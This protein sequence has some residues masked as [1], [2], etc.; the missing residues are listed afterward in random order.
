[1][2][3]QYIW[4]EVAEDRP[5]DPVSIGGREIEELRYADDTVLLSTSMEG[6]NSMVQKD[7]DVSEKY[8]LLIN[9]KKTQ[10]MHIDRAVNSENI[11]LNGE[12][13]KVVNEFDY[14]GVRIANNCNDSKE[15]KRRLAIAGNA[16]TRMKPLWKAAS[17]KL[18]LH[19]LRSCIFPIATYGS[20]SWTIKATDA[21][22]IKSFEM[23]CYRR[24]LRIPWIVRR[25]NES[26]R[27]EI[28]VEEDWLNRYALKQRL[29]FFGHIV[30]HHTLEKTI[31]EGK[32][33]G[34]RTRGRQRKRWTDGVEETIGLT[35]YEAGVVAQDRVAWRS[36][37]DAAT[38]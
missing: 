20:E 27:K 33:A 7:R 1:M 31:L 22:R 21:A 29:G 37:L 4:R 24:M 14:L 25:T 38:R 30:R 15:I 18:K 26:V 23:K 2:H 12:N 10:I 5:F 8:G 35:T 34:K 9:E 13:L 16:L 17:K 36:V 32:I 6:L 3:T 28:G 19:V 11:I